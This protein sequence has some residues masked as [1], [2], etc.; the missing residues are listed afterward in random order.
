MGP[1]ATV[2]FRSA[3]TL[4]I[5]HA[6]LHEPQAVLRSPQGAVSRPGATWSL[7]GLGSAG[8][9][10]PALRPP[11]TPFLGRRHRDALRRSPGESQGRGPQGAGGGEFR[12]RD[13]VTVAP[14]TRTELHA[15][16]PVGCDLT[17]APWDARLLQDAHPDSAPPSSPLSQLLVW[18]FPWPCGAHSVMGHRQPPANWG[19][20]L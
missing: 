3:P 5:H 12:T 11:V 10:G 20:G 14:A 17:A 13:V 18:A 19:S 1:R 15:G 6:H 7:L 16:L 2:G 8:C 9:Q 4:P